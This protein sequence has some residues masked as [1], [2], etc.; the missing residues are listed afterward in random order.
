MNL[1]LF[2]T[3]GVSLKVWDEKGLLD[4]EIILY[5]KLA[6]NGINV[7]F[8]TYGDELD[9]QFKDKLGD[10]EIVPFYAHFKK[11]KNRILRLLYSFLLPIVLR[12]YIA[13]ADLLKTNQMNGSW[14][15]VIAKL[16]FKKKLIVRC[17]YEWY[18]FYELKGNFNFF[19]KVILYLIEWISYHTADKIILTSESDKKYISNKFKL[20]KMD[21]IKVIPNYIDTERFKPLNHNIPKKEN[22]L[23]FIGRLSQQKNLFSLLDAIK[24]T[25]WVLDIVG[26]GELKDELLSFALKNKVNVNFIGRV[27]NNKLPEII[28]QYE[29]FI[30]PSLY[31]GNPKTLLEAMSCGLC[32]IGTDVEGINN[33]IKDGENGIL[34]KTDSKSIKEAIEKVMADVSLRKKLGNNAR[35]YIVDNYNLDKIFKQERNII[36]N[37]YKGNENEN[38]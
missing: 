22:H 21:K 16:L 24:E 20:N 4:R 12:K 37:L 14:A 2:F 19:K 18:R 25:N 10:I 11:T 27:P 7:S 31:E 15:A 23:L 28:N 29:V 38:R 1:I 9:Y 3:Y 5:K 36:Y 13:R 8:I 32:V 17:G 26:D 6:D 34:C 33:I 30:L 35:G